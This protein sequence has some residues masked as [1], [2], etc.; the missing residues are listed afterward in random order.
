[1]TTKDVLNELESDFAMLP[2]WEDR[3][4]Y[5]IDLGKALPALPEDDR[6]DENLVRGC[7]SR[8]WL[9]PS[10]VDGKIRLRADSDAIIVRGLVALVLKVYDNRTPEDI[11]SSPVSEFDRLG[12][13]QHLSPNRANGLASMVSNIARVAEIARAAEVHRTTSVPAS[14]GSISTGSTTATTTTTTTTT[15]PAPSTSSDAQYPLPTRDAIIDALKTVYDPEIPIDIYDLGLIY[16]V[17]VSTDGTVHILMTLTTPNC[18]SA[19]QLP[20]EVEQAARSVPGVID[21]TVEITFDP[22]WDK[23][24]MSESALFQIGLF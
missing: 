2:T 3:Y 12:L 9:V 19:Q 5:I 16:E 10:I 17:R 24:M 21:V 23:T 1:M 18:P 13:L 6:K 15:T 14:D 4:Q 20:S 22:P 7:Q 11:L 8:V